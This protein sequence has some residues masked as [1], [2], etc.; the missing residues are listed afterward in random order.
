MNVHPHASARRL[1]RDLTLLLT[2]AAT[3]MAC[4][5]VDHIGEYTPKQRTYVSPVDLKSRGAQSTNGSLY[6]TGSPGGYLFTDQRAMRLGDIVTIRV[7]EEAAAK[8]GASTDLTRNGSASLGFDSLFGLLKAAGDLVGSEA[9]ASGNLL[10][11]SQSSDFVGSGTTSRQEHVQ[12]TVPAL[13]TQ[14]LPNGNLFVEGHRVVLVNHEE[15]HFYVS[16]VIRPADI[17]DDN[18]V[19]SF[20]IADAQVEFT[21]RGVITEKQKPGWLSRGL[22]AIAPF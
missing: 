7:F 9:I 1:V 15:N 19:P 3:L 20:L 18:S 12:A 8:R 11:G 22:D 16:G 6:A 13:V 4:G 2:A 5:S 14:V 17:L 10:S 21:G